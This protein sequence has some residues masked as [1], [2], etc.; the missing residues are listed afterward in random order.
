MSAFEIVGMEV[1][2]AR[3][4]ELLAHHFEH[5]PAIGLRRK[6]SIPIARTDLQQL[7]HEVFHA[8]GLPSCWRATVFHTVSVAGYCMWFLQCRAVEPRC[9]SRDAGHRSGGT[10]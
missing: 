8:R 10:V 1:F 5:R 7:I 6:G 9:G 3:P 2:V 4:I